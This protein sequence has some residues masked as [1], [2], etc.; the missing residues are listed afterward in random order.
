M[1]PAGVPGITVR[2]EV[3]APG[4][5]LRVLESGPSGGPVV[6]LVHGWGG[7][8]YTFDA[9]IPALAAA[10]HRVLALDLPGHGLSDKPTDPDRYRLSSMTDAVLAVV[11]ANHVR[12]YDVVAHSMGGAIALEIARRDAG[13]RR[14][15]LLGAV[16]V[17]RV[18]LALVVR[19]LTPRWARRTIA[20]MLTR[21]A[22]T[23]VL[24]LAFGTDR[25]P[26]ARDVDEYWAPTQFNAFSQALRECLHHMTW[27]RLAAEQLGAIRMSVLVI[28]GG[29]DRVVRGVVAG[30]QLIPGARVVELPDGGHLAVQERADAVNRELVA[31]LAS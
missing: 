4:L 27:G 22:I 1:F 23:G 16:G 5:T 24:E 29:R 14:L 8:V 6:V 12:Q 13:L 25:R 30:G 9:T 21:T 7:S 2:R 15:V 10:G 3:A 28:A 26:V 18:P 17:G 11:A 31:F 20:P 19:A